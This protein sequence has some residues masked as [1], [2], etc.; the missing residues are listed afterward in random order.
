MHVLEHVLLRPQ[1]QDRYGFRLYDDLGD[2]ILYSHELS[3]IENQRR[4]ANQIDIIASDINNY[5]KK[6]NAD[7]TYSLYLKYYD[8]IIAKSPDVYYYELATD[9]KI[10][11]IIDYANSF[12]NN[13][14][15][16]QMKTEIFRE[17]RRDI[18]INNEFYSLNLSVVLPAWPTRFQN[19]DF[20]SVFQNLF[21]LN[22]PVHLEI[23]FYWL[24]YSEMENFEKVY[25]EWLEER[26]QLEP[27][28][29]EL[30]EKALA[31]V[32]FIENYKKRS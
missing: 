22:S 1:A 30:D 2:V 21:C 32:D 31:I 6:I 14:Y 10:N 23:N 19:A 11:K 25:F 24:E 18:Q 16:L 3:S 4:I 17:E 9:Y 27:I 5:E 7:G 8:E 28:Q 12:K 15:A 26:S 20:K 13:N 29:T